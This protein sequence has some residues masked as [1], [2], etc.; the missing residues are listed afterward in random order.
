MPI[1]RQK[2]VRAPD[3]GGVVAAMAFALAM[4]AAPGAPAI[5]ADQDAGLWVTGAAATAFGP[6]WSG[7]FAVQARFVEDIG[8][9]ERVVLRPSLGY[10]LGDGI[11]ATL[12]YDA[13][14]IEAGR[15]RVEHRIWQQL[16]MTWPAAPVTLGA[17]IRLEERFIETVEAVVLR[18]R[19]KAGARMPIGTG[20][21]YA[22][23]SDEIFFGLNDRAGGPDAGFDQNRLFIGAGRPITDQIAGEF[24]YQMQLIRRPDED[25]MIHQVF[26]SF[27]LR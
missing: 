4:I 24:G 17:Q 14:F 18:L 15:D 27:A 23:I 9:L 6:E 13:H 26:V 22:T 19:L 25:L 3:P 16:A 21:W 2:I 7:G 20:P 8:R 12:G 1:C 11:T 5:A 10:R